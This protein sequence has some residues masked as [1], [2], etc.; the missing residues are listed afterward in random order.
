MELQQYFSKTLN[1]YKERRSIVDDIT[2]YDMEGVLSFQPSSK[3]LPLT[4]WEI[5]DI[6]LNFESFFSD[7]SIRNDIPIPVTL[8]WCSPKIRVLVDVLLAYHSPTFQGIIFVEQRQIAAILAKILPVIPKLKGLIRS[9][10]LVGQGVGPDGRSKTTGSNQ[11]DAVKQFR[12]GDINL[13]SCLHLLF[14]MRC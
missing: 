6:V 3:S 4:F 7:K 5:R 10:S 2:D 12:K 14:T 11:G 13:R 1:D 8:E 9:A